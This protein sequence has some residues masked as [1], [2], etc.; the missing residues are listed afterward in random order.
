MAAAFAVL[1]CEEPETAGAIATPPA[2]YQGDTT[3]IVHHGDSVDIERICTGRVGHYAIACADI[4]GSF[5]WIENPCDVARKDHSQWYA[6]LKCEEI[7]HLNGWSSD[8][9]N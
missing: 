4:G 8:H 2:R 5:M 9:T 6:A 7:G 1:G 3:A